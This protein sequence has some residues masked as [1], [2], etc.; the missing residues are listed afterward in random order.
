MHRAQ[1]K[2]AQLLRAAKFE[3]VARVRQRAHGI[4]CLPEAAVEPVFELG[5]RHV[6]RVAVIKI[7]ERQ[8]KLRAELVQRHLRAAGLGEDEIRRL[9]N[10]GQIVHQRA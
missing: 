9:Q 10:G 1:K 2:G 8:G 4:L 6:R 3:K 7:R 5:H